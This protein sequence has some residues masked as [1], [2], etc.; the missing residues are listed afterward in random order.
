[1]LC[2]VVT[3][4][5]F[6]KIRYG[7]FRYLLFLGDFKS[8]NVKCKNIWSW[9]NC[10]SGRTGDQASALVREAA[11]IHYTVEGLLFFIITGGRHLCCLSICMKYLFETQSG[12]RCP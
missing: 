10:L 8:D 1:M 6:R 2:L 4:V 5:I 12:R 7:V 3:A 9:T 11:L